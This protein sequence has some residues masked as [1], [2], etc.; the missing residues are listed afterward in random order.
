VE[1]RGQQRQTRAALEFVHDRSSLYVSGKQALTGCSARAN[2]LAHLKLTRYAEL[3]S[4][5]KV[6]TASD[7]II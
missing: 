7:Q 4:A 1:H 2:R 3:R 6:A 5:V